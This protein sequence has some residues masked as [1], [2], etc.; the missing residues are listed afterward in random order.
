MTKAQFKTLNTE[1]LIK[2]FQSTGL[3]LSDKVVQILRDQ[4]IDGAG[5]LIATAENLNSVGI[6][7]GSAL[8]II[9]S[10]PNN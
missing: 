3:I 1:E 7:L 5:L 10:I 2:Y 9:A 6:P 8:K 4:E